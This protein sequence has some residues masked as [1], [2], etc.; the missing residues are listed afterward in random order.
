M[1]ESWCRS[2]VSLEV[3]VEG[4]LELTY[5]AAS[6]REAALFCMSADVMYL[7]FV[8]FDVMFQDLMFLNVLF[9][10]ATCL[11]VT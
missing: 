3:G 5:E 10:N 4:K 9:P 6:P 8:L 11:E 7:N 2:L 1:G